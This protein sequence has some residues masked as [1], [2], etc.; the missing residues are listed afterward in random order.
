MAE[1]G[2]K[3]FDLKTQIVFDV[4][5]GPKGFYTDRYQ[6]QLRHAFT[7][8]QPQAFTTK[9][10]HQDDQFGE[11]GFKGAANIMDLTSLGLEIMGWDVVQK[12]YQSHRKCLDN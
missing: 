6:R 4:S 10:T 5:T 12:R 8:S 1:K 7:L 11:T 9:E 2:S 3:R